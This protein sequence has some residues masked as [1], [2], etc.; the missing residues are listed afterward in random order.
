MLKF[1]RRL[2]VN[3]AYGS[4][5]GAHEKAASASAAAPRPASPSPCAWVRTCTWTSMSS[6]PSPPR[7]PPQ[8]SR[9]GT[10]MFSRRLGR[11]VVRGAWGAPRRRGGGGAARRLPSR[12]GRP[13]PPARGGRG[14]GGGG[15]CR[16]RN[17]VRGGRC[18]LAL[19][20]R[21][22]RWWVRRVTRGGSHGSP[23]L[24]GSRLA[25]W[26]RTC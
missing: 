21:E 11:A 5:T 14:P 7:L 2:I 3:I 22:W 19:R 9:G 18:G 20:W 6:E 24:A 23:W 8:N 15:G 12:G 26:P 1:E 25:A 10:A 16:G 4:T 13:W 17:S